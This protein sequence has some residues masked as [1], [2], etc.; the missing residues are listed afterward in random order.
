[1]LISKEEKPLNIKPQKSPDKKK[2]LSTEILVPAQVFREHCLSKA[3]LL[4]ARTQQNYVSTLSSK[5]H[6]NKHPGEVK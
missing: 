6:Y 4:P 5:P 2:K 3:L 1:M